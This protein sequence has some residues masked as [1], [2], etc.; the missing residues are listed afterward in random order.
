MAHHCIYCVSSKLQEDTS[1]KKALFLDRDGIINIDHGYVS[2][3]EDF[4]FSP[5]IFKLLHLFKKE[6]YLFFI[7]TNQSGIGRGYYSEKDF[8]TLTLWMTNALQ[9]QGINIEK[10][11]HCPHAPETHCN[12]RKPAIGMIEETAKKYTLDMSQSWMIGDKQSDI[13]FA[14]HAGIAHT[15]GI[16]GRKIQQCEYFFPSIT[17]CAEF[18][19]ENPDII[20]T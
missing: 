3:I 11:Y 2:R 14:R 18:L 9:A 16:G 5:D 17:T 10:V 12:C 19:E 15:I 13:D 8:Q 4:E 7:V 6:S 20:K 1:L